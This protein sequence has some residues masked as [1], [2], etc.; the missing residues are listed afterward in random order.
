MRPEIWAITTCPFS[1]CTRNMVLGRVSSTVPSISMTSSL[2][3]CSGSQRAALAA[4]AAHS[5]T[6]TDSAKAC[7]A[8][9]PFELLL[10]LLLDRALEHADHDA[11]LRMHADVVVADLDSALDAA[12]PDQQRVALPSGLDAVPADQFR[13]D[14][15]HDFASAFVAQG[16]PPR[17]V[18]SRHCGSDKQLAHMLQCAGAGQVSDQVC[19]FRST[20][21][22]VSP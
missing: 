21:M 18:N 9:A 15:R 12:A 7:S 13:P 22:S 3:M 11:E 19:G 20:R 5:A 16:M 14:F 6:G 17:H 4:Q 2:A 1:S 10:D 8:E